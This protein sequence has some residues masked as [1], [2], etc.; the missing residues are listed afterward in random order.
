MARTSI[1]LTIIVNDTTSHA[2]GSA[3]RKHTRRRLVRVKVFGVGLV[4]RVGSV[5]PKHLLELI[6]FKD[7][8]RRSPQERRS[9]GTCHSG[10]LNDLKI[11]NTRDNGVVD[12][13][14]NSDTRIMPAVSADRAG[15]PL[16]YLYSIPSLIEIGFF[17]K[18]SRY[19][20]SWMLKPIF[21]PGGRVGES[22][23]KVTTV[24]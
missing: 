24:T 17:F 11:P 12:P 18:L 4:F 7:H 19:A 21:L 8:E 10:S 13:E 1:H 14:S 5:R 15:R 3:P 6:D 22:S 9:I 2:V 23:S 20:L 16:T